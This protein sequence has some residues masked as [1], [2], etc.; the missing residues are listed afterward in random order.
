MGDES[1]AIIIFDYMQIKLLC[2]NAWKEPGLCTRS[3][4][5]Q[6]GYSQAIA[7]VE[8]NIIQR[9]KKLTK[10]ALNDDGE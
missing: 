8:V 6:V 1:L 9:L 5:Y 10:E 7:D 4:E 3:A 2:H